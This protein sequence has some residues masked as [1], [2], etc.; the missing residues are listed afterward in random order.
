[1]ESVFLKILNMSISA[2]WA[3][4]AVLLLR[5][6]LKG[7]PKW[8]RCAL[9]G[10][11]GVRLL[12]PFSLK[13]HVSL[14]P[15]SETLPSNLA[16]SPIPAIDSG[17]PSVDRVVNPILIDRFSPDPSGSVNPLQVVATVATWIWVA[18]IAIL[19]LYTL[20]SYLRL[21]YRV[22]EATPAHEGVWICDHI[23]TPF[24][25][26]LL[27]PRIY[28]PS[29]ITEED[30]VYVLAHERAHLQRLDF[31]WKPLAFL[32]LSV[33]WFNPLLW[34]AFVLFARDMEVACDE[35]VIRRFG[36][37]WKKPYS[38]ALINCSVPH[39]A[40]AACPL[41]FG[42]VGVKSR[43]RAVLHYK[44]PA[45]WVVIAAGILAAAAAVCLL[46]DPLSDVGQEDVPHY[47]FDN[48]GGILENGNYYFHATVVEMDDT[49]ITVEPSRG[50]WEYQSSDR[51]QI[52]ASR[53]SGEV[54][55][56]MK[57]GDALYIEYNG[58]IQESYPA[59]I[60]KIYA[61]ETID[62]RYSHPLRTY[63][64]SK[65]SS[66]PAVYLQPNNRADVNFHV[67]SSYGMH[68]AT[69]EIV[70]DLL[71]I[72]SNDSYNH[73]LTFR[74]EGDDLVF[75]EDQSTTTIFWNPTGDDRLYL[76]PSD[77]E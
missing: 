19:L 12:L 42:E 73:V 52:P 77:E 30:T 43:I 58:V 28:L 21:R 49:T 51:I 11:V 41:A 9:W 45:F 31:V 14:I 54:L 64:T 47:S 25:L 48:I 6:L 29:A 72:K 1:M 61:I 13:S 59:R 70:G 71:I 60:T 5:L 57:T 66:F 75:L 56:K 63:R 15:S 8:I 74:M 24:L 4:L 40:I 22:R 67:L 32:L 50:T 38:T 37:G 10:V 18:G 23:D 35:R 62:M 27:R 53:V 65:G 44:K 3:V 2:G 69:Y 33:H 68:M 46:T 7:A 17:I 34:L 20:V 26:G 76:I 16:L 55:G 36:A 39:S